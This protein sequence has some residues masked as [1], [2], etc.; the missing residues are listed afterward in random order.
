MESHCAGVS[1]ELYSAIQFSKRYGCLTKSPDFQ[2]DD[3][4]KHD[5]PTDQT[6]E[7]ETAS[8]AVENAGKL[9][10]KP[11]NAATKSLRTS[12]PVSKLSTT[13]KTSAAM[14]GRMT[15]GVKI[16]SIQRITHTPLVKG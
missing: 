12:K 7:A 15:P 5:L 8:L 3:Q 16:K 11:S 9:T 14:R 13:A 4:E 1:L 10:G 6:A 2:N